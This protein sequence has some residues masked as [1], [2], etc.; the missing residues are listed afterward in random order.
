MDP[1]QRARQSTRRR[2]ERNRRLLRLNDVCWLCG[3]PGADA[4]DHKIPVKL[5]PDLADDPANL[6]PAHHTA[7]C[8]TC[9]HKCNR[10]KSDKPIAPVMRR[11]PGLNRPTDPRP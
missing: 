8:P 4:I 6:A 1:Y 5:R 9:G 3:H 10:L 2:K 7:P 11:S